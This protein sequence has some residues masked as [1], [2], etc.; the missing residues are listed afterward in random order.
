MVSQYKLWLGCCLMVALVSCASVGEHDGSDVLYGKPVSSI[1]IS[2]V[3][4]EYGY[5]LNYTFYIDDENVEVHLSPKAEESG[6]ELAY[7]KVNIAKGEFVVNNAQL[8]T[9]TKRLTKEQRE[10][11][12]DELKQ[13]MQQEFDDRLNESVSTVTNNYIQAQS[14]FYKKDY[15]K[16]LEAIKKTLAYAPDSATVL[17]LAGS[18]YYSAGYIDK[19]I[20][21][22]EKALQHDSS[23]IQV[24]DMLRK[25]K[26]Q[27]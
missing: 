27:R 16:A 12:R 2:R 15:N 26:Q 10:Q 8:T 21:Y 19:A 4:P 25:A 11:M 22:W 1:K 3:S 24:R 5:K 17:S 13:E 18:I 20:K 14:Y 23:L 9:N 7:D 6:D